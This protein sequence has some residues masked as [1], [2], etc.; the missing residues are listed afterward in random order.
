MP[1]ELVLVTGGSGFL[2]SHCIVKLLEKGYRVRTTVRRPEREAELRTLLA[3][4]GVDARQLEFAV[5][6]LSADAAWREAAAGCAFVLHVASPFPEKQP[7]NEDELIIP[8]R[9][10]SLR[11]LRAARD[12][13]V[14][15]VVL[16]SSFAAVGYRR[17]PKRE[18]FTEADW[19]DEKADITPYVKSKTVAERAA[20]EFVRGD[21]AGLELAVINPVGIF[22]P[23]LGPD[24]PASIASVK[25]MLEG[26][27]PFLPRLMFGVVDVRDVADLHIAAMT[28][29][30]A[31]G[32][33]FIAVAGDFMTVKEIA[34]A[35]KHALGS[36][37]SR[38]STRVLPDWVVRVAGLFSATARQAGKAELGRTKNASSEKARRLLGWQPRSREEAIVASGRSLIDRGLLKR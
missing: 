35:L 22:G 19:T 10:G 33:R 18:P 36:A 6:D 32:E 1:G 7:A 37:A 30:T 23:L 21:G 3:N 29:P 14:K 28:A 34:Q 5:A 27:V 2:G 31:A 15:R 26:S 9:D 11:V 25:S 17:A 13:G 24:Y 4:A 8:A 12:A 16:T 20:W 38:V